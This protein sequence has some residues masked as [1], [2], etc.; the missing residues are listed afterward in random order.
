MNT[1][2]PIFYSI[3]QTLALKLQTF[4]MFSI[5]QRPND[6]HDYGVANGMEELAN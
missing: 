4:C 5:E 6:F 3:L 1:A 2:P